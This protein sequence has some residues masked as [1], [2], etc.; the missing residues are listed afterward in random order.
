MANDRRV[1]FIHKK[2]PE[3]VLTKE[4]LESL[5]AM[6]LDMVEKAPVDDCHSFVTSLHPPGGYIAIIAQN[7]KTLEWI[8]SITVNIQLSI[9]F[10]IKMVVKEDIP[11]A[12]IIFVKINKKGVSGE[13]FLNAFRKWNPDYNTINWRVLS[14]ADTFDGNQQFTIS[15][16]V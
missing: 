9:Q 4:Q 3:C 10:P 12:N 1:A 2:H 5:N 13:E 15:I 11:K 8:K 7:E 6:L 14:T 16:D